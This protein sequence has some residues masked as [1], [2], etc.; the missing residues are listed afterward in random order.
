MLTAPKNSMNIH[1]QLTDGQ[2]IRN[3]SGGGKI[4]SNARFF[5]SIAELL[6]M[7][8]TAGKRAISVALVRHSVSPSVA[9][10]AN[11]SRTQRPSVP[12]CGK[13]FPRLRCDSRTSFK[14]KR[15]KIRVTRPINADTHRDI[16]WIPR[17]TNFKISIRMEDEDPHQAQAQAQGPW[18][19]RL[20]VKIISSHR[21]HVSSLP[22]LNSENKTRT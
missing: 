10:I 17:P 7:P 14:V 6:V 12:K 9:Y 2:T 18:L 8:P 19:P 11:N 4:R 15:P 1:Q 21:L 3:L 16:F 22:L 20:K 5:Y 13:K